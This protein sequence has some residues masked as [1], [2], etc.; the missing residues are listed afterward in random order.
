MENTVK[1]YF[2]NDAYI[3]N[4]EIYL[5]ENG[6]K[7]DSDII[8]TWQLD[9]YTARL[10]NEGYTFGYP[11]EEVEKLKEEYEDAKAAYEEALK[12]IIKKEEG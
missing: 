7:V 12:N 11:S 5:Y 6:V 2:Y 8:S 1:K 9:G 3:G 4:V 10:R